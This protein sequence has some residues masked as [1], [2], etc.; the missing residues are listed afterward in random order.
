MRMVK[1]HRGFRL[2]THEKYAGDNKE[3]RLLQESSAVGDYEDS[4]DCPGSSF[5]WVTDNHHLNRE[6]VGELINILQHWLD[7]KRLPEKIPVGG[8]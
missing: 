2:V 3:L 6:E 7:N 1:S 8:A 5:L 4:F